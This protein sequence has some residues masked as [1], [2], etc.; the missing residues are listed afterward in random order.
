MKISLTYRQF[1][2]ALIKAGCTT[3]YHYE[4]PVSPYRSNWREY[5]LS[6]HHKCSRTFCNEYGVLYKYY[7]NDASVF[8]FDV[9][10]IKKWIFKKL[11]IL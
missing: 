9:I 5:T 6:S 8:W 4:T 11:T 2:T 10:D 1:D 7:C 3:L